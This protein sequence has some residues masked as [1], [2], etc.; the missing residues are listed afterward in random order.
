[1]KLIHIN[2]FDTVANDRYE[3]HSNEFTIAKHFDTLTYPT[4]LKPLRGMTADT[5][6]TGIGNIIV[7]SDGLMYGVGDNGSGASKLWQRSGYGASDG[8]QAIPNTGQTGGATPKYNL[9]VEYIDVG[10]N[11]ATDRTM[12]WAETGNIRRGNKLGAN[13]SANDALTFTNIGQGFVHPKDKILYIPYDNKISTYALSSTLNT[14]QFTIPTQYTIPCLTNYGNYL[15]IPGYSLNGVGVGGSIVYLWGRDTSLTTADESIN[16]GQG[17]L[18]VLNN[19][20][21]VLIGISRVSA[22]PNGSTQDSDS[23]QIK[24]YAGGT[25]P[26]LI[27]ELI[28]N[29]IVGSSSSPSLTINQNVN[30]IYKNRMYFSVNIVPNDGISDSY[31]GLW[32]VG[33]NKITGAYSVNMERIATNDNSDTGVLAAAILGDFV[34]I[35]HTTVGTLTCTNNGVGT[36]KFNA[37]STYD[38]V[39][40]PGMVIGRVYGHDRL[41]NKQLFT[42]ALHYEPLQ[43]GASVTLKYKTDNGSWTTVFTETTAGSVVT[44]R[45]KDENGNAFT[46]GRNFQFRIESTGGAEITG[47]SYKYDILSTSL[48]I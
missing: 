29:H 39:I 41:L 5:A 28:A 16:W 38:S 22:S 32:S 13:S 15:A 30:F 26:I 48:T 27:K 43:S 47:L 37:T 33:K 1:M 35:A 2:R 45:T 19:L 31:Y 42:L 20:N 21:G 12:F 18:K 34:S 25:E 6:N 8:W 44:E 4:R 10:T 3:G 11:P 7:A 14:A 36:G 24:A 17:Q 46:A 40:N 23:I 9:L